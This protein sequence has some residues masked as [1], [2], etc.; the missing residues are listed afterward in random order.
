MNK[1]SKTPGIVGFGINFFLSA[2]KSLLKVKCNKI[3][4]WS[5]TWSAVCLFRK[6]QLQL[7]LTKNACRSPLWTNFSVP[8]DRQTKRGTD[9]WTWLSISQINTLYYLWL[10]VE[11]K[12]ALK[13]VEIELQVN[14]GSILTM[15]KDRVYNNSL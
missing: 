2:Y 15:Q 4:K 13:G 14:R 7:F 10:V 8:N 3:L 6:D 9:W 11:T 5:H 1:W 12:T